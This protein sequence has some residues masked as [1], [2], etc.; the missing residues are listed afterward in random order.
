MSNV[1][2]EASL[3]SQWAARAKRLRTVERER[4]DN[5]YRAQRDFE[6]AT[7]LCTVNDYF[8]GDWRAAAWEVLHEEWSGETNGSWCACTGRCQKPP[9]RCPTHG[10]SLLPRS[11]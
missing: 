6:I 4:A 8:G 3:F 10:G 7:W 11:D 2:K 1:Q 9:Y 5:E